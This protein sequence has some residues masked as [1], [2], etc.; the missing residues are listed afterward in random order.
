MQQREVPCF[1]QQRG[2]FRRAARDANS[3]RIQDFQSDG[4][5]MNGGDAGEVGADAV[6]AL[7]G[8]ADQQEPVE[9]FRQQ[10]AGTRRVM[11]KAFRIAGTDGM[12]GKSSVGKHDQKKDGDAGQ[13]R[14]AGQPFPRIAS[15]CAA[16]RSG[17]QAGKKQ[18]PT[19]GYGALS[20]KLR[21]EHGI[22]VG[23][24]RRAVDTDADVSGVLSVTAVY[25]H[26]ERAPAFILSQGETVHFLQCSARTK[27]GRRKFSARKKDVSPGIQSGQR[28]SG[29]VSRVG[30]QAVQPPVAF[31]ILPEAD[32]RGDVQAQIVRR[33]A[34]GGLH[35]VPYLP[36]QG[37][38][39]QRV[40]H[41]QTAYKHDEPPGQSRAVHAPAVRMAGIRFLSRHCPVSPV[42][43]WG[44]EHGQHGH[45]QVFL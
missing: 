7:K 23:I 3:P 21:P 19:K 12:Q 22:Q 10:S 11:F 39:Q 40:I 34:G 45:C 44:G 33:H 9:S 35:I 25:G 13:T 2:S 18:R 42:W 17:K 31:Q 8:N 14:G 26:N 16:S 38:K 20:G 43:F 5:V 27:G 28:H 24:Q 41:E 4:S 29:R 32:A 36:A 15:P 1:R 6:H 37:G 30:Q